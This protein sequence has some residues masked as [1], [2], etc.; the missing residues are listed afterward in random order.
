M[1]D[2]IIQKT[3]ELVK[4]K[5]IKTEPYINAP[6]G[7]GIRQALDYTLKLCDDLGFITKDVEGY[8]GHA[9]YGEGKEIIGILVHLD[10][11]PEGTGWTYD[12]Y[13]ATIVDGKMY[14]RGVND[15]KGAAIA[16]IYALKAI[17]DMGIKMN[18]RIRIIFGCDEESGWECMNYYFQHEEMPSCGFS[19]DGPFPIVNREKGIL[20]V[21]IIKE[22]KPTTDKNIK[23]ISL[24]GGERPN[25]VPDYCESLLDIKNE[26]IEGII[27]LINRSI[28]ILGGEIEVEEE[29][30]FLKIK[31]FG[32]SAHGSEPSYGDNAISQLIILLN[33]IPNLS[34][35]QASYIDFLTNR[36]G[37]ELDGKSLGIGFCDDESGE[38]SLNLGM[39]SITEEKAS[40]TL[41]IRYPVTIKGGDIADI[42]RTKATNKNIGIRIGEDK[43]PLYVPADNP[44]IPKLSKAYETVLG[45]KPELISLKG[46]TY[47]RAIK[48]AVA[49]GPILPNKIDTAHQKDEYLEV[50]D[51][52]ISAKIYA[53][54]IY[55]L[56]K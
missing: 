10:V 55:E 47:A 24:V 40:T 56:N 11:V 36:I 44:L 17:K 14:G 29:G 38:L 28:N 33:E 25:M 53:Q 1:K 39:I 12:P 32:K 5:S 23:I 21:D 19:P 45:M 35:E 6:F 26:P 31:S 22:F 2:A 16:S 48:N 34:D 3:K 50:E 42:I 41:D 8:A 54:A 30:R 27:S 51:L 7:L 15:D 20:R 49:F 43:A 4:I 37:R 18:K 52:I 9:E 13:E 46:G